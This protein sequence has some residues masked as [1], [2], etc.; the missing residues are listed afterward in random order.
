MRFAADEMVGKLAR[1]LRVCGFDVSY[2]RRIA[3]LEL[4]RAAKQEQ[5]I[6]ITRDTHLVERLQKS[7]YFFIHFDH[8]EKQLQEFFRQFPS[9][10]DEVQ[11]LTRCIE[12]NTLLESI[13][14]EEVKGKVWPYVY[15]TQ[16]QFSIC[17]FCERIYW[18]ATHVERI[19]ER[20]QE[21]LQDIHFP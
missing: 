14:K 17:P 19:R 15:Q 1:W 16:S 5:R 18:Q 7:D 13:E 12:C 9:L 11:F 10:L 4:I 3:D 8:L 2:K 21:I 20:L 6:I